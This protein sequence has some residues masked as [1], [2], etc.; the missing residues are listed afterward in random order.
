MK[1]QSGTV[2]KAG[3]PEFHLKT[4][5]AMR[6]I[7][8]DMM[9]QQMMDVINEP[10]EERTRREAEDAAHCQRVLDGMLAAQKEGKGPFEEPPMK[11]PSTRRRRPSANNDNGEEAPSTNAVQRPSA[12]L[13]SPDHAGNGRFVVG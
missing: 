8:T 12:T 6:P 2:C 1:E 7:I 4:V 5:R 13:V 11:N 10:P 9:H 3:E